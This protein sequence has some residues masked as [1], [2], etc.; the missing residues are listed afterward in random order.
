MSSHLED[1]NETNDWKTINNREGELVM[2]YNT[3]DGNNKIHPRT[4]YALYIGLNDSSNGHLIFKLLMKQILVTIKYQPIYVPED[5]T[6]AINETD[7]FTN[8]IQTNHFNSDH[9]IVQD[10]YSDNYKDGGQ[11][12]FNNGNN[13]EDESDYELDSSQQLN[14][15]GLN[16][17][18][19]QGDQVILTKGSSNST[20]VSMTGLTR[21]ITF[22]QGL[23]LQYQH[24]AESRM[25]FSLRLN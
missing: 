25:R 10:N 14:V 22:L 15:M 2:A 16:K 9:F 7:L 21:A 1:L 6:K 24:K 23:F 8:K 20:S 13:P 3:N 5:L 17:I 11:N 4:F 18:I 12:H 19:D